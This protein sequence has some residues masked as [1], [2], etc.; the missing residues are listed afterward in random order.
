MYNIAASTSRKLNLIMQL[1]HCNQSNPS[2]IPRLTTIL[3][4][5][6]IL[7]LGQ[8]SRRPLCF[9]FST[10]RAIEALYDFFYWLGD[11]W[12]KKKNMRIVSYSGYNSPFLWLMFYPPI[13]AELGH[14]VRNSPC[15]WK[16]TPPSVSNLAMHNISNI[17]MLSTRSALVRI[18]L[19]QHMGTSFTQWLYI[20]QWRDY[21]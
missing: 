2:I 6:V 3:L 15:R 4:L 13:S 10:I 21:L 16:A 5:I 19:G 14:D 1:G 20:Q 11:N 8:F 7:F 9:R 17:L 12:K 18:H